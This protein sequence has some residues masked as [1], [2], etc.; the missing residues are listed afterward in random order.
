MF[1]YTTCEPEINLGGAA[2]NKCKGQAS[3]KVHSQTLLIDCDC[4]CAHNAMHS[5]MYGLSGCN[6]RLGTIDECVCILTEHSMVEWEPDLLLYNLEMQ[7]YQLSACIIHAFAI[8]L[9]I[10][11]I[12]FTNLTMNLFVTGF[13]NCFYASLTTNSLIKSMVSVLGMFDNSIQTVNSNYNKH[14]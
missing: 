4:V 13:N 1:P 2:G 11:T 12:V 14:A 5:I 9:D 7:W 10:M 6:H 3:L 8:L